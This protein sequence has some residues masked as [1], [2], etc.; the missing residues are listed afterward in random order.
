[1]LHRICHLVNDHGI[2]SENILGLTFTRHSA[3]EMRSRLAPILS[4]KAQRVMLN[5]IHGF[6]FWLLKQEGRVF[7]LLIGKEQ[8]IFLKDVIRKMKHSDLPT[9]MV[10]REINLAK[11]NMINIQEFRDLYEGDKTMLKIADIYE[12]YDHMKQAAMLMDFDDLLWDTH[13][14]L[15]DNPDICTR[16]RKSFQHILVDEYQDTNPIQSAIISLLVGDGSNGSSYWICGDDWQSIYSFTGASVG[17]ILNFGEMFPGAKRYL[18]NNNFRSTP[19][20]IKACQNLISHNVRKI[21]KTLATDNADGEDVRILESSSEETESLQIANEIEDLI[22][23]QGYKYK[24]IAILYRANFQSRMCEQ[25]LSERKIPY[26]IENGLNFYERAEVRGLL[27]YLRLISNPDS[28]Q[29][30]EALLTVINIPN[31][32]AGYR[33]KNELQNWAAVRGMHLYQAL[34]VMP[35]ELP[36]VRHNMKDFIKFVDPLIQDAVNFEPC[37]LLQLIRTTLDYDRWATDEDIPS[38]DD[39]KILNLNQLQVAAAKFKQIEP[40]LQFTENFQGDVG[41]DKD[42]VNLM[43]IHKAKGLEFQ[44]VFVIGMVEGIL[45]SKKGDIEEE[46]RICF[47]AISR[48]MKLLFL[49][50]CQTYLGSSCKRSIFLDEIAGTTTS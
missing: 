33:F 5:T 48:A 37:E 34:K 10:L 16:Y 44:V 29:G 23:T 30:D 50:T 7:E 41:H 14:L 27:N 47:V 39:T 9:G 24:D 8:I 46:R 1:M 35:I 21:E 17:N 32:Y 45:P 43:T 42:G 31:R 11:A 3:E 49:S 25:V 18:L 36:Y 40:F 13:Q 28:A 6:C 4:D 15:Q 2:A 19:Q 20:I 12:R 26:H 38:P 22:T